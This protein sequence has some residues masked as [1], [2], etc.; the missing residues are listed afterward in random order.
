MHY[1]SYRSTVRMKYIKN[2]IRTISSYHTSYSPIKILYRIVL[3]GGILALNAR[4]QQ[5]GM[6]EN[7]NA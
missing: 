3:D 4:F 7:E 6:S 5:A 1:L 2:V